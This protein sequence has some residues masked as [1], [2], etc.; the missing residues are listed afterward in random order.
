M[1]K[2]SK[3]AKRERELDRIA[4]EKMMRALQNLPQQALE[5]TI[6]VKVHPSQAGQLQTLQS[7]ARKIANRIS[8]ATVNIGTRMVHG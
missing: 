5:C 4:T 2:R 3:R 7:Q 1:S 6:V 8:G